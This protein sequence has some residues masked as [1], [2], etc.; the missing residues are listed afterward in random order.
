[1]GATANII[2]G[3]PGNTSVVHSSIANVS[4]LK[5]K[6]QGLGYDIIVSGS[7]GN[8]QVKY[9]SSAGKLTFALAF[10]VQPESATDMEPVY[11]FYNT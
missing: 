5:V 3:M 10:E 7:P 2:Y 1:M 4:M 9:D 6:R 8:R 11:V